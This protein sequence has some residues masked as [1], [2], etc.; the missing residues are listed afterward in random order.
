MFYDFIGYIIGFV[1]HE[2]QG[3]ELDNRSQFEL[4]MKKNKSLDALIDQKVK[5]T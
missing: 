3:S 4:E 2:C 1:S 5:G